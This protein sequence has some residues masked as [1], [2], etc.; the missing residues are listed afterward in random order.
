MMNSK[1][2]WLIVGVLAGYVL[3]DRIAQIPVVNKLPK[4]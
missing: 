2:T 1:W 4:L 3:S